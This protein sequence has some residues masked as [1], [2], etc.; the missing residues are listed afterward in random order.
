MQTVWSGHISFGL[1]TIPVKML[2]ATKSRSISFNYVHREC[3]TPLKYQRYCPECDEVVPWED[4]ERGYEYDKGKW[5]IIEED[6]LE[7]IDLPN[8]E[9]IDILQFTDLEEIDPIYFNKSYYLTPEEGA[10]KAYALLGK[11]M[12]NTEKVALAKVVIRTKQHLCCLRWF[13]GSILLETMYYPNEIRPVE[14]VLAKRSDIE[15]RSNE[16]R[17]ARQLIESMTDEFRPDELEDEYRKELL[18]IIESKASGIE[19]E[20]EPEKEEEE[21]ESLVQALKRSVETAKATQK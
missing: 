12:Q 18:K 16:L 15:V 6:D 20:A 14:E 5:V 21:P 9:N 19:I 4:V 2:R 13:D 3:E 1:V 17:M 7:S 10:E 8:P 11:V